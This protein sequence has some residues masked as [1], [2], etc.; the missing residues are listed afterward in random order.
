MNVSADTIPE[1]KTDRADVATEFTTS[2]VENLPIPDRNFANLQLL[3]PGAQSLSW[4]HAADE[5]PQASKQIQV[6]GQAFGGVAYQLDGTDNQDP[7]LGIIVINPPLD[8]ISE[9][10][11]TTQNFDA[12]FGKAVSSFISAQTKSGSNSF[13]GSAFDYRESSDEP[14]T[15]P[16]TQFPGTTVSSGAEE[17]I[18]RFDRRTDPQGQAV[19]LRRL[20]GRAAEGGNVGHCDRA[21][22]AP[23]LDLPWAARPAPASPDAISANM[24]WES[25]AAPL[26]HLIYQQ[27]AGGSVPYPGNVIPTAQLSSQAMALLQTAAALCAE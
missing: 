18:R 16:Y 14:G 20:S 5:N 24:R 3:L 1:L 26:P 27:T 25:W 6:D 21:D 17:P 22:G 7:I 9:T 23:D 12:E 8:A 11:I 10:K 2:E 19:L 4:N 13:H 15:D